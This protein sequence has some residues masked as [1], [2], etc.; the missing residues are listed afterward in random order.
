LKE[1]AA[2]SF[3]HIQRKLKEKGFERGRNAIKIKI[4][5]TIGRK[6]KEDYSGNSLAARFG[7][8]AHSIGRWIEEGL[9]KAEKAGTKRTAQQGGDSWVIREEDVR[10]FVVENVE[11]VDF[12]K[13]D[14]YWLVELLTTSHHR[15]TEGAEKEGKKGREQTVHEEREGDTKGT[16]RA[17][18]KGVVI[19]PIL[20][21]P[22][23]LPKLVGPATNPMLK[24]GKYA[25]EKNC[26]ECQRFLHGYKACL[27]RPRRI[28]GD[29]G[30][31]HPDDWPACK[32]F[33]LSPEGSKYFHAMRKKLIEGE[34]MSHNSA[35][36]AG[37][38]PKHSKKIAKCM[39]C[40]RKMM[41]HGRG[42]C[43]RCLYR[44]YR[45]ERAK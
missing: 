16:E 35:Q 37:A 41:I 18:E 43:G 33:E 42:L 28:P 22:N 21:S 9:M 29:F 44:V 3:N 39:E 32:Y 24:L 45:K 20:H 11:I 27:E 17:E 13:V 38:S 7:I 30:Q 15:D 26:G 34:G 40:E 12:R 31:P 19:I 2:K 5:R 1:H 25:K 10:A 8:D 4:N 6:P 23:S 14:K 36:D